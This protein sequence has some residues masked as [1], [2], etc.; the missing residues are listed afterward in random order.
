MKKIKWEKDKEIIFTFSNPNHKDTKKAKIQIFKKNKLI[1][2]DIMNEHDIIPDVFIYKRYPDV[3]GNFKIN[4]I[5][6][7]N[8]YEEEINIEEKQI[9][10]SKEW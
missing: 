3:S 6:N 7:K 10:I 8:I 5:T 4:Y 9:N 2:F 1:L